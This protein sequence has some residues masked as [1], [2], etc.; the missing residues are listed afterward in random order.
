M[1]PFR[2]CCT[3][4]SNFLQQR[5]EGWPVKFFLPSHL[6]SGPLF[7]LF[8]LG[9]TICINEAA[10]T[11]TLPLPL[12]QSQSGYDDPYDET[13]KNDREFIEVKYFLFFS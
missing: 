2:F 10:L 4:R 13:D 6:N 7:S 5:Q 9:F 12:A 11:Q 1:K 3:V 8:I